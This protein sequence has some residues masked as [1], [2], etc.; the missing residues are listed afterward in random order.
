MTTEPG[1]AGAPID[2]PPPEPEASEPPE[3]DAS[4][5]PS[6]PPPSPFAAVPLSGRAV[7]T[8]SFELLATAQR[9]LR[10]ASFYAGWL[11]LAT[12]G[13]LALLLW[14]LESVDPGAIDAQ[15]GSFGLLDGPLAVAFLLA[16]L[17]YVAVVIDARAIAAAVIAGELEQRP[18][19]LAGAVRLAR[20]RF[21]RLVGAAV[22]VAI[23][24]VIG[25]TA[26]TSVAEAVLP[27]SPEATG[28][29]GV[30]A[31]VLASSP[32]SYA[33][34]G[35]VLGEVPVVEALRR[36]VRLARVRP[37][38]ALAVAAFGVASQ[39]LLFLALTAGL[40]VVLRLVDAVA[41]PPGVAGDVA[42]AIAIGAIVFALGTLLFTA[43]ALAAAPQVHA[44][45]ALT[46]YARGLELAREIEPTRHVWQPWL[47][48]ALAVGVVVAVLATI[49]GLGAIDAL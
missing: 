41:L 19:R 16:A 48:R 21:W 42:G 45:V 49:A 7:V 24:T 25:Q 11:A 33:L 10:S 36:S 18:V 13:P 35:I 32:F 44:F 40:D 23:P 8:A 9:P 43:E 31:G 15:L 2:V 46:H 26:G 30:I 14:R 1:A 12:M 47:G 5:P 3:P 22:I 6:P 20:R 39:L 37:R 17:G 4:P 27:G 34:A 28:A 38:L 29:V